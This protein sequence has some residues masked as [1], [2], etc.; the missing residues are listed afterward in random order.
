MPRMLDLIRA[1]ALP[2]HQ[3][4]SAS[5]GALR[6]PEVEMLEILVYI[7]EHNKIF[8]EGAR[9]TLAGWDEASSRA[10][11]ADPK[12]PVEI[13]Q[14][15]LSAKNIRPALFPILIE[16][17]AVS[18]T[19]LSELATTLKKEMLDVMIAS[20][21]VRNLPQVLQDLNA[22]HDL[23][24]TQAARVKALIAGTVFVEEENDPPAAEVVE[25]VT[26]D[27][28]MPTAPKEREAISL[29]V[30]SNC[31]PLGAIAVPSTGGEND[32]V[33]AEDPEVEVALDAFLKEHEK[34][35]AAQPEKPFH[36]IGGLHE[37]ILQLEEPQASAA[38]ATAGPS[39]AP[40][41]A[42]AQPRI[43]HPP[44]VRPEE[45]KRDSVLQ[46]I[47]RLDIKGRIQ[48]AMKGTKEE[49][50]IL[51]RD[52]T[53][54]IALAVLDSPKITDG[55]VEKFAGQ[56]NVLEAV[57]R[58]I[59]MKRRFAKNYAVVRALVFNPRTPLDVSLGLMKNLLV[60]D[61]KNLSGNKEVAET[62]RKLALRMFRQKNEAAN[63]N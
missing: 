52:G 10:I 14:Y 29:L 63:K 15:W 6:L 57:L 43:S 11:A 20:P 40:S 5:K 16:N 35:I 30:P 48:L 9:L 25:S 60:A 2:S 49:R 17:P 27:A 19:R 38:A 53:K 47:G 33:L 50:A 36:G 61:L 44:L 59:P 13:L 21:R 23:S 24:G 7:A 51:V 4:M 55:E 62:V 26:P 18:I 34:E 39:A 58:A 56:K 45:Q 12:T 1:S 41:A 28:P 46:K 32:D 3:M 37:D 31:G 54:I 42:P 8:G 22:N